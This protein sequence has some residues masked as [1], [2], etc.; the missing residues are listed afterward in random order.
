M[1]WQMFIDDIHLITGMQVVGLNCKS[2]L[3]CTWI[4]VITGR[5]PL[6]NDPKPEHTFV[7]E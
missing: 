7:A 4:L 1:G 2:A 5:Y 6:R 3:V